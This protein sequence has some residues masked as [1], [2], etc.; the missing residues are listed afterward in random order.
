MHQLRFDAP[1]PRPLHLRRHG[2]PLAHLRGNARALRRPSRGVREHPARRRTLQRLLHHGRR[3]RELHAGLSRPRRR[4]HHIVVR[5]GGRSR[6]ACALRREDSGRRARARR[7][8]GERHFADGLPRVLPRRL[9]LHPVGQAQRDQSG[10]GARLRRRVDG[11]LRPADHGAR[12]DSPRFAFR[13]VP[14]SRTGFDAGHRRRL[15]RAQ[16]R[17][18]HRVRREEVRG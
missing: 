4:G 11:G 5:Q 17:G 16:A 10:A 3:R 6:P 1:R 12:P 13:E 18:G 14:Q 8:R 15:R 7:L 2:L 9:R